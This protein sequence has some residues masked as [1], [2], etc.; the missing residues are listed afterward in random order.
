M[1]SLPVHADVMMRML[2]ARV[3]VGATAKQRRQLVRARGA[4]G[5]G[6]WPA[7]ACSGGSPRSARR[8]A[9]CPQRAPRQALV[10]PTLT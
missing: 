9:A 3:Q 6:G 2:E 7:A 8:A 10:L 4:R 5:G 1:L